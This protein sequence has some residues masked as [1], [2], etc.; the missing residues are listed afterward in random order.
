MQLVKQWIYRGDHHQNP[1]AIY[2]N[3]G[4]NCRSCEVTVENS[5][6]VLSSRAKRPINWTYLR[7]HMMKK[8]DCISLTTAM[9]PCTA[10][11]LLMLPEMSISTKETMVSHVQNCLWMRKHVSIPVPLF[12]CAHT[13]ANML[14][15]SSW[16]RPG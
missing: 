12:A 1:C 4:C 2:C 7:S 6:H 14:A 13:L 3:T 8:I 16:V 11:T 10:R 9:A 5:W 15:S